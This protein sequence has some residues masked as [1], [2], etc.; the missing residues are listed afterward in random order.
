MKQTKFFVGALALTVLSGGA[1]AACGS[2]DAKS[3]D[4]PATEETYV[5]VPDAQVTTGLAETNALLVEVAASADAAEGRLDEIEAS[6]FA[7]EGT[8]REND[9]A[10]YLDFEDALAAFDDAAKAKDTAA[11]SAA[12]AKFA[13]TSAAYLIKFP[14]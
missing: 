8:V 9:A 14:G 6:W 5:L 4:T 13:T 10:S 2:D 3:S 1:L 12:A 11:M 7:Y